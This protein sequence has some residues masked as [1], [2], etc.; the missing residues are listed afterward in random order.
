VLEEEDHCLV[1][2]ELPGV[3]Q[4]DIA[5]NA[6]G[7]RLTVS[8]DTPDHRYHEEIPLPA[9]ADP[10]RYSASYRNGILQVKIDK[11]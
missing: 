10:G 5:L 9:G 6:A 7:D 1:L 4:E 8:V 2:I 11:G 3:D